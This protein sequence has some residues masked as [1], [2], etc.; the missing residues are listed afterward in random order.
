MRRL[1]NHPARGPA[2]ITLA[3]IV[4]L[5]VGLLA[6]GARAQQVIYVNAAAATGG[7]G[8]SWGTAYNDLQIALTTAGLIPE[9]TRNVEIWITRGLYVPSVR[10][11]VGDAR[12]V[13]F[14]V[15]TKVKLIGSFVGTESSSKQHPVPWATT[16]FPTATEATVLSADLLADDA[17][18]GTA[19]NAYRVLSAAGLNGFEGLVV[20]GGN[21]N[22]PA[23]VYLEGGGLFARSASG[24]ITVVECEFRKCFAARGGAIRAVSPSNTALTVSRSRF[25]QNSV[26]TTPFIGDSGVGGAINGIASI[27]N[28]VFA[29][30]TAAFKGG[31]IAVY[32]SGGVTASVRS[33][34]FVGNVSNN[35]GAIYSSGA[36]VHQDTEISSCIFAPDNLGTGSAVGADGSG[37]ARI[38]ACIN[39]FDVNFRNSEPHI[40]AII[41]WQAS[42]EQRAKIIVTDYVDTSAQFADASLRDFRVVDGAGADRGYATGLIDNLRNRRVVD[43]NNDGL[44]LPDVGA[45]EHGSSPVPPILRVNASRPTD[46]DG[47]S[48]LTAFR[49]IPA[50]VAAAQANG[51]YTAEIWIARGTYTPSA[52]LTQ[53][54]SRAASFN[55]QNNLA[56]YGGFLGTET[57]FSQR[58]IAANPTILSGDLNGD[59]NGDLN[60]ADN[61]THVVL[62]SA[63]DTTARLDGFTVTAG[64]SDSDAGGLFITGSGSPSVSHCT[65]LRNRAVNGAAVTA[66]VSGPA[67]P[68]FEECTFDR[69]TASAGGAFH[70]YGPGVSTF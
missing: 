52:P 60:R 64:E 30:N 62:A 69:N 28:S 68:V 54:G 49:S 63:V 23:G 65:F 44:A 27:D 56:I 29:L 9:S 48:W 58:N 57:D 34:T 39:V 12:S 37:T 40:I 36:S 4:G 8:A 18:V 14:D 25:F 70:H 50:A 19:D 2:R 61:S 16:N 31:A 43:G 59:D 53:G 5:A 17:T 35:G 6:S 15:P 21:A 67:N 33:C 24:A 42:P 22:D 10:A 3:W 20:E 13:V 32:S 11:R 47:E 55:L 26:L 51:G 38:S 1:H 41:N 66:R 46:G 45:I 7:N